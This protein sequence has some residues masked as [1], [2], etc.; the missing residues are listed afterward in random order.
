MVFQNLR[1]AYLLKDGMT[2]IM[3][4]HETLFIICHVEAYI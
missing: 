1:Q 4:I 2:Q 3:A